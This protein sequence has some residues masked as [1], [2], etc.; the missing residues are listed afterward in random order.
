MINVSIVGST[1]SIGTQA[2]DVIE[3]NPEVFKVAALFANSNYEL[4]I[5]QA[6]RYKPLCVF[7]GSKEKYDIIRQGISTEIEL[8]A[9]E[10]ALLEAA[11][12]SGADTVLISVVGIAGLAPLMHAI[13]SKKRIAL[14]NKESIVCAGGLIKEALTE[15]GVHIY[16]V[17]S[18]HSAIFQCLQ[19]VLPG[20]LKKIILTASGGAFKDYDRDKLAHARA[21]EALRHPTWDMGKKITIDCATMMNKGLEVIEACGLFDVD[22]S[23]VDVII[24]PQSIVHSMIELNDNSVL[25]QLGNPDMRIPIQYALGYPQRLNTGTKPLNLLEIGKLTF[26]GPDMDRFPCLG[27]AYRAARDGGIMPTVLNAANES[28]VELYLQ[29]RIGYFDIPEII[30][31][32]MTRYKNTYNPTLDEIFYTDKDCR[33]Y[34]LRDKNILR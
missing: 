14:A 2:L 23:M 9:G 24:H 19:G 26:Y 27:L 28:A 13:K 16:P 31:K 18:E 25:A 4:L 11:C 10:K 5:E 29:D 21:D 6:M 22:E 30:S 20:Q 33:E 8:F 32:C 15:N 1:G 7:F 34:I 12:F 17:D 3:R